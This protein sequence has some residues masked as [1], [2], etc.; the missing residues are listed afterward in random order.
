MQIPEKYV[1]LFLRWS[2]SGAFQIHPYLSFKC[3]KQVYM[4]ECYLISLKLNNLFEE[5]KMVFF[6]IYFVL[7]LLFPNVQD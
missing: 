3:F 1:I 5:K 4:F 2:E 7:M 6:Q